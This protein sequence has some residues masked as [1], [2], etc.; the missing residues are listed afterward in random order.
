[1][2][3]NDDMLLNIMQLK[4]Q[5]QQSMFNYSSPES[6]GDDDIS[7][8]K[9]KHLDRNYPC[10]QKESK[11]QVMKNAHFHHI[12]HSLILTKF[13]HKLPFYCLFVCAMLSK[14]A[15][16]SLEN[17]TPKSMWWTII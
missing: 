13:S 5:V 3:H 1:M 16:E 8:V 9:V 10:T 2:T 4:R 11:Q 15:I 7:K 12:V 17:I 14:D 6:S